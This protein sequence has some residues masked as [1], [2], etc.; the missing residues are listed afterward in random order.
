YVL[1]KITLFTIFVVTFKT[2][3]CIHRHNKEKKLHMIWQKVRNVLEEQD[4][5]GSSLPLRCQIH[6]DKVTAVANESDFRRVSEGG[7]DLIC[8][9]ILACGHQCKSYCHILN[10]DHNKYLCQEKCSR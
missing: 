7:C 1:F 2:K 3:Y 10:R 9:Q 4:S 5:L 6:R 8:G